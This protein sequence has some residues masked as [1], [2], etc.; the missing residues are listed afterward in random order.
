MSA[1]TDLPQ[2]ELESRVSG[3]IKRQRVIDAAAAT[4][5]RAGYHGVGT[6]TIAENLGIKAASLYCHVASKEEA[7][8]EVCRQGISLPLAYL[9]EA[10]AHAGDMP[11]RL[12]RFF[13][14]Q[15]A[16]FVRH[17]D[18]VTVYHQERRHLPPD[19]RERIEAIS[20]EFRRELDA[21]FAEAALRGELHSSLVPR[22][23]SFICIGTIRNID[24]LYFDGPI[25]G[26]EEVSRHAVESLIRGLSPGPQPSSVSG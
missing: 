21:M 5:A 22:T 11:S 23:A 10:M 2:F 24:Q 15:E 25:R 20:R 3:S 7:L 12:K 26:F 14:L 8:E 4:F 17:S 18:F 9:R 13:A 19:A 1:E 16:Y 6:R